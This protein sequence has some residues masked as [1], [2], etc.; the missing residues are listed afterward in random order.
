MTAAI[1]AGEEGAAAAGS[2]TLVHRR[3]DFD[4]DDATLRALQRAA[5][6]GRASSSS[7]ASRKRRRER[8]QARRASPS[9]G[10]DGDTRDAAARRAVRPAR[11][12][13]EARADRRLGPGAREEA[14]R[15]RHRE[16]RD[17][18]AGDLRGRR[19]QHLSGQAEADRLRLPRGDARRVRDRR[20]ASIP[21][22]AQP[23]QYTTTSPKLHKL[24]GVAP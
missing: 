18:D 21:E 2:V 11:L 4:A 5:R 3:D 9:L 20:A 17:L 10:S 14:G 22:R 1:D 16:L 6:V 19:R 8:R 24:L 13:P 7:P 23:L 15:R 12:E